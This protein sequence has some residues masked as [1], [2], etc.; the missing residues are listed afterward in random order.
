MTLPALGAR[1][2]L[3]AEAAARAATRISP[4]D[5]AELR[6]LHDRIRALAEETPIDSAR[7]LDVDRQFHGRIA[8]A[9]GN[10]ALAALTDMLG[11]RTVPVRSNL[12]D[13]FRHEIER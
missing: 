3:E 5:L 12:E 2:V 7:L 6:K 11:G 4:E 13:W 8:A 10:P 9:S 1:R